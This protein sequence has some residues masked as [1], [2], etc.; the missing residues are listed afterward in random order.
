MVA[1]VAALCGG[2][3]VAWAM[4]LQIATLLMRAEGKGGGDDLSYTFQSH[5]YCTVLCYSMLRNCTAVRTWTC[6][7]ASQFNLI[8]L[9]SG[10]ASGKSW[11]VRTPTTLGLGRGGGCFVGLGTTTGG[12]LRYRGYVT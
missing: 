9:I 2:R 7:V 6:R 5:V 11:A 10:T 8:F 1:A 4:G 3:P 12:W